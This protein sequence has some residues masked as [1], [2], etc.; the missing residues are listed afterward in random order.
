VSAS[1][2]DDGQHYAV[3]QVNPFE[4]VLQVF[5]TTDARAYSPN[6]AIWQIQ[7]KA[8]RPDHTWRSF[9]DLPPIEQFFN[10][11]LWDAQG[12]LHRAPANPIMDIGGMIKAADRITESLRSRIAHLP[13]PLID[14]HECWSTDHLGMPVAL[15]ATTEDPQRVGDLR[16]TDWQASRLAE[17]GFVSP[18]LTA[19]GIPPSGET[20]PRQHAEQLEG[21]VRRHGPGKT[22][23]RRLADGSGVAL[24]P[25]QEESPRAALDFPVLGL[26]SDWPDEQVCALVEDYLS[27]ISP[28]LLT[29]QRIDDAQRC[30]LEQRARSR[31]MDLAVIYRLL[32][33]VIDQGLLE[34]ARVEAK[35]RRTAR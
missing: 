8:R 19:Q 22:W 23:F 21:L 7:V 6:G 24:T 29:L 12:G 11:G 34:T 26:K 2:P 33:R 31:A 4:G 32:P 3:R 14:D 15:L 9:G 1:A 18:S 28:Q 20:G 27:W 30:W 16:P 5:E 13:F 35:L 25:S 17:H 10:F